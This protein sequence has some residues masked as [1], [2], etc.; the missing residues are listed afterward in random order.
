MTSAFNTILL[1]KLDGPWNI[2]L[3][4][5]QVH[6]LLKYSLPQGN[7]RLLYLL[8]SQPQSW[9]PSGSSLNQNCWRYHCSETHLRLMSNVRNVVL[10][11]GGWSLGSG[12]CLLTE[13]RWNSCLYSVQKTPFHQWGLCGEDLRLSVSG[14]ELIRLQSS[15]RHLI[16]RILRNNRLTWKL[17]VSFYRCSIE[18]TLTYWCVV[19]QLHRCR[20]EDISEGHHHSPEGYRLPLHF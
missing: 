11:A 8:S 13:M 17:L 10:G 16:L 1:K 3:H 4:L 18:S 12:V 7:L 2:S 6:G 5:P 20:K 9:L 15:R 14:H 19:P